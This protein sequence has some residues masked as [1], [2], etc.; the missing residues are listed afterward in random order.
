MDYEKYFLDVGKVTFTAATIGI[1]KERWTSIN[2]SEI[3]KVDYK[4]IMKDNRFDHLPIVDKNG[5]VTEFFKAV[6]L[7]NFEE[8]TR[9]TIK[10]PEDTIPLNMDIREVIYQFSMSRTF[11]FLTCKNDEIVGLI[12]IGNLNSKQVYVFIYNLIC[13]LEIKLANF[14]NFN[15][16][17][18]QI[19]KWM[20][21]KNNDK[22][23][24]KKVVKKFYELKKDGL[25]NKI[26][27][28]FFFK[29][30]FI[31]IK[32]KKLYTRL[33]LLDKDWASFYDLNNLRNIIAHPARSIL[34]SKQNID[35]LKSRVKRVEDLIIK[36]GISV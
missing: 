17:T 16:D 14:V 11:F 13:E 33:E 21:S 9:V 10:R 18:D 5:F 19:L 29:D 2:E 28:L 1:S 26:T 35:E 32:D 24:Y 36:L 4:K 12:T 15:L 22:T 20:E 6:D 27:E 7:K 8:V 25:E 34:D 30:F 31:L 23:N 3:G